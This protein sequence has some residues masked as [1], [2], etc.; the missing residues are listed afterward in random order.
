MTEKIIS[1][2]S[3]RYRVWRFTHWCREDKD[4]RLRQTNSCKFFW[5]LVLMPVPAG[6]FWI[7]WKSLVFAAWVVASVFT[8]ALVRGI[9][10]TPTFN[11][12]VDFPEVTLLKTRRRRF[13]LGGV[14]E[15]IMGIF[16]LTVVVGM[17]ITALS[18]VTWGG[19]LEDL[20]E[21]LQFLFVGFI[22]CA[23]W[24]LIKWLY[25]IATGWIQ[26]Q[27]EKVCHIVTFE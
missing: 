6:I 13:T 19:F 22:I 5:R 8:V 23:F 18:D 15:W 16:V 27:K 12:W 4:Y 10:T 26:R 9:W 3:P 25:G 21:I 11:R 14:V 20:K 2:T 1:K 17:L 24:Y 7:L